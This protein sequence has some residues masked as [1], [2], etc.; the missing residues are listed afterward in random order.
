M[1]DITD[2]QLQ[3][4]LHHR[5]A[6]QEG[7]NKLLGMVLNSIMYAEREHFLKEEDDPHNKANGYRP[8]KVNGYGRQLALAIPRDRLGTFQPLMTLVLKE[9]EQ[10]VRNLC[11]ALYKEGITTRRIGEITEKLY[12]KHYSRSAVSEIN[13]TFKE[14]LEAWRNKPLEADYVALYLDALAFQGNARKR[15]RRGLLRSPS[16]ER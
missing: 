16:C 12:G 2:N 8:I 3:E 15:A 14:N 5:A 4:L 10:E 1:I 13:Q 7:M 6:S 9:Q 11:F